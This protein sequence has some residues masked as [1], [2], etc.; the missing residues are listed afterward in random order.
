MSSAYREALLHYE[1]GQFDEARAAGEIFLCNEAS[2]HV[3]FCDGLLLMSCVALATREFDE[4]ERLVATCHGYLTE[5]LGARHEG[6]GTTLLNRGVI[7]LE[8]Y[9]HTA[10]LLHN[11]ETAA[12][13]SSKSVDSSPPPQIE[14]VVDALRYLEQAAAI[15]INS[16]GVQRLS[17]ADVYHN[18][19]CCQEILGQYT[20]ALSSHARSLRIREKFQDQTGVTELKL[21]LTMEHIAMIYRLTEA[22]LP[23]AVRLLGVV[24]AT[25]RRHL[26]PT[27]P[28]Y[29]STLFHQA[30]C[31]SEGWNKKLATSLFLQC[32]QAQLKSLGP[33]HAD[34]RRTL[35]YL[36][37]LSRASSSEGGGDRTAQEVDR[38]MA[39]AARRQQQRHMYQ[40]DLQ[41][42]AEHAARILSPAVPHDDSGRERREE[43]EFS[44]STDFEVSPPNPRQQEDWNRAG[45][46]PL[47][48]TTTA[49][50]GIPTWARPPLPTPR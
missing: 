42:V 16:F 26:G 22:K 6:T 15:L 27:H 20:D 35:G 7:L 34:T 38:L 49:S 50:G 2:D 44:A 12:A 30:V 13:S 48:L 3:Q 8:R 5:H 14:W 4:A 28:L 45:P 37:D 10:S 47:P 9:R 23:E 41:D 1:R 25:R 11:G 33:S 39:L 36:G 46:P 40:R 31:A 21:A 24:A 29:A 19:G 43:E 18:T 32:L 17:L